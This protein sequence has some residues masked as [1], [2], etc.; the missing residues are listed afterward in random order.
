MGSREV[1]AS[2]CFYMDL[3]ITLNS[4]PKPCRASSWFEEA[5]HKYSVHIYM[6]KILNFLRSV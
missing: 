4:V 3:S 2:S 1:N 6:V 5:Q